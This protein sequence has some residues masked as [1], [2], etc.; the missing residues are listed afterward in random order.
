[1]GAVAAAALRPLVGAVGAVRVA[2]AAPHDGHALG[3]VAAELVGAAGGGGGALELV[4]A[5]AAVVVAAARVGGRRALPVGA[6]ELSAWDGL[7]VLL[8]EGRGEGR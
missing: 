5:V 4:A 2:V 1:M 8:T 6:L 3:R 7:G